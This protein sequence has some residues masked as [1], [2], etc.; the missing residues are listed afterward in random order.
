MRRRE[1]GMSLVELMVGML[2]GLIGIVIITHLYV[3]NEQYKRSTTGAGTA[4]VNG[5]VAL[6]ILERDIRVAG[7]GL[8]F[9]AALGCSCAGAGCSP[10]Q[11]YYN[12]TYSYPPA[13][14]PAGALPPL[15]FAPVVIADSTGAPDSITV[16]FGSDPE[17]MLPATLTQSMPQPSAE[18]K[19]DGTAGFAPNDLVMVTQG[20]SCVL[21]QLT[22]VQ[23]GSSH[24]QHNPAVGVPWNPVGGSSLLP[25]FSQ[26]ASLFNLGNP[27]WRIYSIGS[28]RLRAAEVLTTT[29]TGG[30]PS[31]VVD[32]IVDLQAEY[33]KDTNGDGTVDTWNATMPTGA[34]EWLQVLAVRLGVLVRSQN[35]EKPSVAGGPCEATTATPT[36]TGS[37]NANSVF[38]VPGGLPSCYKYRAFETVV[39]LRNMI[40]RPA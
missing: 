35:F 33:G 24:L 4:Q 1:A 14:G 3:T 21:T 23:A 22:E 30:T 7:F 9:T 12:G 6:Y 37:I 16:L 17:R 20:S 26:G 2:I 10:V 34:A 15:S 32:D 39:P 36:W 27:T 40:W 31:A 13:G 25:P 29:V 19:V 28:N 18:F 11:Y 5:A 8:N 38:T